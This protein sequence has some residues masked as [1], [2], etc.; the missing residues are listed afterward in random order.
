MTCRS[1]RNQLGSYLDGALGVLSRWLLRRHL[2]MCQACFADYESR[3]GLRE[4]VGEWA[5]VPFPLSVR[6]RT[7][8]AV[9]RRLSSRSWELLTMRAQNFMRPL[10]I[11][12]V[13]GVLSAVMLF[14]GFFSDV[15]LIRG[16]FQDDVP[17]T[18]LTK[19]WISEPTLAE[20]PGFA[21]EQDVTVE[22]FI[23]RSGRVYDMRMLP[24]TTLSAAAGLKIESQIR[25][26]LLTTRFDPATRFGQ[27]VFG[28]I[29]VGFRSAVRETVYG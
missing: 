26:I 24:L 22:V 4:L 1:A 6:T 25:N 7:L 11:P 13:G 14:A 10:A 23:D 9:S 21:P 15:A 8:V 17:L 5:S 20:I 18:Y 27:P 3:G 29:L 28:R 12:A 19:A 2:V 16:T